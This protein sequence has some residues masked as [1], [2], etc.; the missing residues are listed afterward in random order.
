M[1]VEYLNWLHVK[2]GTG[3][4]SRV[5]LLTNMGPTKNNYDEYTLL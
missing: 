1:I 4:D 3:Q 2:G 5:T